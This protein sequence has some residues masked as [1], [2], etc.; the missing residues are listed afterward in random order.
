MEIKKYR[1]IRKHRELHQALD[2]L[3]AD[4]MRHDSSILPGETS[5]LGLLR[6]SIRQTDKSTIDHYWKPED[7][8]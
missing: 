4:A 6:W 3:L 7:D 8:D 5:I 1:H 2:E